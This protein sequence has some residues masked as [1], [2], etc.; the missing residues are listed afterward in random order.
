MHKSERGERAHKAFMT[1]QDKIVDALQKWEPK[2]FRE[3]QW[4]REGGGGGRTRVI[5]GGEVLEKGG[6][7]VSCV[8]GE[9]SEGFAAELPGEGR[10]FMATGISLVLHP[11]NPRVPTVHANFRY[12][13]KG[14]E[15]DRVAWFGGGGDLTPWILYE[16][17]AVHFH[18]VWKAVCDAHAV[19][20][21]PRFKSWC[22]E[23][24][25]IPHRRETRGVGGIFFD[26][27]GLS[28]HPKGTPADLDRAEAFVYDAASRFIEAYIP[29]LT[30]RMTEPFTEEERDWQL[31]RRSRYVEFN[32]VY[33]RGTVF[34]LR[35]G[36]RTESILMSLPNEV[37]WRY[38]D[39]IQAGTFQ[40]ALVEVL[41]SPRDWLKSRGDDQGV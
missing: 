23:Y 29:I 6:V 2:A 21:Y 35:T 14:S 1:H 7:N 24:F 25:F 8:F 37:R 4:K 39:E 12:L 34:G 33:D 30:Q 5:E 28:G 26:Y 13:E 22:D 9:L 18:S 19:A 32:L 15:T 27:L 16:A 11:R 3:D 36:G 38:Q 31:Y 20:D 10:T 41:K 40:E 17:D